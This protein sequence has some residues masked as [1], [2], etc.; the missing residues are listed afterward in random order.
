MLLSNTVE[1]ARRQLGARLGATAD[2]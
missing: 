2:R 1:A